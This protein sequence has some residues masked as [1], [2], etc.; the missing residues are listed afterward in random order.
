MRSSRSEPASVSR[1]LADI[2]QFLKIFRCCAV[3]IK[4]WNVYTGIR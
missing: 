4:N 1:E 3:D 2:G